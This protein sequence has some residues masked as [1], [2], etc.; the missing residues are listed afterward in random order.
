MICRLCCEA[1]SHKLDCPNHKDYL[2]TVFAYWNLKKKNKV[3]EKSDAV[4]CE[5]I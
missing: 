1:N 5:G 4:I 3:K 2:G